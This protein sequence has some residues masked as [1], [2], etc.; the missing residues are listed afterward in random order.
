MTF[1]D[2]LEDLEF[3]GLDYLVESGSPQKLRHYTNLQGL[4]GILKDGYIKSTPYYWGGKGIC[5]ARPSSS[6]T[7]FNDKKHC[8]YFEIDFEVLND[9]IRS[10]TKRQINELEVQYRTLL[11][12][13]AKKNDFAKSDFHKLQNEL[14]DNMYTSKEFQIMIKKK[15]GYD[16]S[17]NDCNDFIIYYREMI[18]ALYYR[19]GEER[20]YGNDIPINSK[21]IKFYEYESFY[22]EFD[23]LSVKGHYDFQRVFNDYK[24][25]F[26]NCDKIA[27]H[28]IIK[29]NL[30]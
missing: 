4:S 27:S 19:E 3:S 25:I 8:G 2:F 1:S 30:Y 12:S 21:Y 9:K 7:D 15:Y 14:F 13:I 16:I 20:I 11:Q 26:I 24:D 17:E 23:N 5:V 28:F 6:I 22:D 29:H 10:I 18:D